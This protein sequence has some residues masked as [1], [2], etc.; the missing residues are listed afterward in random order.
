MPKLC[1]WDVFELTVCDL[2]QHFSRR[3]FSSIEYVAHCIDYIRVINPYLEAVIEINPD[4]LSIAE[5]LD[6]DRARGKPHGPLHG[7][8]V[9]I[10]DNIATKDSTHTTAGSWALLGSIVPK[11]A[12]V[13]SRLRAA[14]AVVLG[15]A[16][17]SEWACLRSKNYSEGYSAR[18]G[19]SRNPYDL[20]MV[21]H[22][23]SSGSAV[24]V[25]AN[26]VP[27]ALGTETDSSIIGPASINAVVGI[28]PTVGLTSRSGVIPISENMDTVGPFGRTVADAVAL[29]DAIVGRDDEDRFTLIPERRQP[30]AYINYLTTKEVLKGARFGLVVKR[31]WEL[32][33]ARCKIVVSKLLE[34]IKQAGADIVEVDFPSIEER[35]APSGDWDWNFGEPSKREATVANVDAYNGINAYLTGLVDSPVRSVEEIIQYNEKN[36]GTEGGI[37]GTTTAFPD[38]QPGLHAVVECQGLHDKTYHAA[39][40]HIRSQTRENGIDSALS[41]TDPGT[42]E[43]AELDALLFC[44]RRGIGQEYA[45]QAGYPIICIPVGLDDEGLPVSLSLQH[46]AWREAELVKWAS[47]IE[48][49]WNRKSGWRPT[50]GFRNL[51]A[52]NIPVIWPSSV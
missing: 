22:G 12:F 23:S 21:P 15:H 41:Y 7:V 35:V 19:Q 51:Q 49:L 39:L 11:D 13:I 42:G 28:K 10:K 5:R 8:P 46:S 6:K 14:G 30:K 16:N 3:H 45:A 27:L 18:G 48:D 31:C 17:M 36:T 37:P 26:L 33:P 20:R 4:A 2:Q 40:K 25:A 47:A 9:L 52:K 38:G 44:D 29:L 50:P 1:G 34:S 32:A 24:A 43:K